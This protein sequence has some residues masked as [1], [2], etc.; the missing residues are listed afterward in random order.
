MFIMYIIIKII[1]ESFRYRF[2]TYK[3]LPTLSLIIIVVF[4]YVSFNE[5]SQTPLCKQYLLERLDF[6][7]ERFLHPPQILA[8]FRI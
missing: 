2:Q 8:T 7:L 6:R 4:M 1:I 5:L 3:I